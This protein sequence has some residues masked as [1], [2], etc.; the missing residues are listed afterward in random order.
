MLKYS[1]IFFAGWLYSI[2]LDIGVE[3]IRKKWRKQCNYNCSMCKV[4]DC[5]VHK[6]NKEYRKS[7]SDIK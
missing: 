5:P 3:Q 2:L 7:E 6:C 4:W 1:L